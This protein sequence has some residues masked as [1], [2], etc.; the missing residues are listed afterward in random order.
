MN[1][2]HLNSNTGVNLIHES[3][4][5]YRT[6]QPQTLSEIINMVDRIR[7]LVDD[8]YDQITH[9]FLEICDPALPEAVAECISNGAKEVTVYPFFLNSGNHVQRDI[10]DMIAE[11]NAIWPDCDISPLQHFGK[12]EDIAR[13]IVNHVKRR[14]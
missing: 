12:S 5:R 8:Q 6:W 3:P 11:L 2:P 13:L 1:K 10:P 7:S 14:S 9:S 4:D